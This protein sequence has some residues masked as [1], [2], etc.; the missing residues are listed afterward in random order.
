MSSDSWVIQ[1]GSFS[2]EANA[3]ALRNQLQ[4]KGF[5]SFVDRSQ[6]AG[7]ASFR[8]RVGPEILRSEATRIQSR[9]KKEMA[10]DGVVMRRVQ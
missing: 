8:V 5:T 7:S 9:L 6:G 4:I 1:V 10:L 3:F 2:S